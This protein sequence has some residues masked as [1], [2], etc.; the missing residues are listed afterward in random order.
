MISNGK[1]LNLIEGQMLAADAVTMACAQLFQIE[2]RTGSC[3]AIRAY[4]SNSY[5]NLTP[6]GGIILSTCPSE[7]ATLWEF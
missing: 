2:L 5:L 1:Y 4:D 7:K 3:I 6:N